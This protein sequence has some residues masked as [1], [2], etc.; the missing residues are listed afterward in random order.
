MSPACPRSASSRSAASK[1][2]SPT[3]VIPYSLWA[4]R[5]LRAAG[6]PVGGARETAAGLALLPVA[7]AGAHAAARV[8][9]RPGT[10]GA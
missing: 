10:T 5:R 8:L 1:I 7:V 3:V 2:A 6:I 4:L 9:A